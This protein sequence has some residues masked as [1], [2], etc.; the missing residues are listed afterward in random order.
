[1]F[2]GFNTVIYIAEGAI[3]KNHIVSIIINQNFINLIIDE[4]SKLEDKERR[5]RKRKEPF[6][7]IFDE[8]D[9]KI[10]KLFKVCT[11]F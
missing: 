8:D 5:K 6:K 1:M 9:E 7:V 3:E 11:I 2:K 4:Q 10:E